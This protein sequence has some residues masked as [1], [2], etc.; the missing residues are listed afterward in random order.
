MSKRDSVVPILNKKIIIN[1]S[2][3]SSQNSK[4]RLI[5]IQKGRL[6][7]A[8]S[9]GSVITIKNKDTTF[10]MKMTNQNINYI[11]ND[12]EVF[13]INKEIINKN[14][15][16][17]KSKSN[18]I[19]IKEGTYLRLKK[20]NKLI[21]SGNN[22][23][24]STDKTQKN[25]NECESG[26]YFNGRNNKV[27]KFKQRID[28]DAIIDDIKFSKNIPN[29]NINL[30]SEKLKVTEEL[31]TD[32]NIDAKAKSCV[33]KDNNVTLQISNK[34]IICQSNYSGIIRKEEKD[35]ENESENIIVN[36]NENYEEMKRINPINNLII[37]QINY[38]DAGKIRGAKLSESIKIGAEI[39]NQNSGRESKEEKHR[40]FQEAKIYSITRSV[41]KKN[42]ENQTLTLIEN[43]KRNNYLIK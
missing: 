34:A 35:E 24:D 29:D 6:N 33:N 19:L 5:I 3:K 21:E 18:N 8:K 7:S 25:N 30:D 20:R 10:Q 23:R 1:N 37:K 15:R 2:M 17:L 11:K 26:S 31:V 9:Q 43:N 22:D 36:D 32:S 41:N 4:K 14:L 16:L 40:T 39:T 12:E 13:K 28:T 38:N 42:G 27:L